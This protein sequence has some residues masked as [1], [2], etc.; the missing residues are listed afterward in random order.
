MPPPTT[1]E[2]L[3]ELVRR[4]TVADEARLAAS[5]VRAPLPTEPPLLAAQLIRDGVLTTFQTEQFLQGKWRGFD[6]GPFRVLERLGSRSS[7]S[8]YLCQDAL[9]WRLVAVKVLP[10]ER[11][12]DSV[13]HSRFLRES[14]A[15]ASLGHPNFVAVHAVSEIDGLPLL[16]MEFVDGS[17]LKEIVKRAGPMDALRAAHYVREA[18]VG[19]QFAHD[20]GVIHRHVKP[21]NLLLARDGAVKIIDLSLARPHDDQSLCST[22]S[23][24]IGTPDYIAPEQTMPGHRVDVRADVYSLG[25]AFYFCLAGRPPFPGGTVSE[26]FLW[27]QTRL[28]TPLRDLRPKTPA[29]LAAVVERMMAKDPAARFQ[30][31]QEVADA[32][33]PYTQTPIPPPPEEEMPRHCPAVAERVRAAA[34]G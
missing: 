15:A 16:V 21:S 4:S 7:G 14:R 8:I 33:A 32:L 31:A 30:K 22:S 26:K 19:L 9:I 23:S 18:A 10:T 25:C 17:S 5:L 3:L 27:H 24:V 28:P 11:A 1:A 13:A 29:G 12:G 6:L 34:E 2:E 20:L